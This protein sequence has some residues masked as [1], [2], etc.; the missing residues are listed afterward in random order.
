MNQSLIKSLA[1]R[2]LKIAFNLSFVQRPGSQWR[3]A[4]TP[5]SVTI[6]YFS[7]KHS[8]PWF[9]VTK[10]RHSWSASMYDIISMYDC[11]MQHMHS[12]FKEH[13]CNT[14]SYVET[15]VMTCMICMR[16][17]LLAALVQYSV[18][19]IHFYYLVSCS[20]ASATSSKPSVKIS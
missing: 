2:P 15:S 19:S 18:F 6:T 10:T 20:T 16:L 11:H 12:C 9:Q 14:C 7:G 8:A 13:I 1:W 4:C 17:L 5:R 3:L